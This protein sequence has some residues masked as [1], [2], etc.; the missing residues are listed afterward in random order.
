MFD[1]MIFDMDGTL[2]NF[3]KQVTESWNETC[4]RHKW[5]KTFSYQQLQSIMGLTCKEIGAIF[6]PEID[7]DKAQER[8]ELCCY[9]EVEYLEKHMGETYIPNEMFLKKLSNKYKLFIVSNCQKGY[10]EVFLKHFNYEKYFIETLNSSNGLTK[11]QNIRS[12][13]DKYK[14][15]NAVY[16]GDTIKDQIAANEA[17]VE[18]IHASYGFGNVESKN[19]ITKLEELLDL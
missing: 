12:L 19:K 16:V 18:F 3:V 1:G 14:L 8:V 13:V 17:K 4:K 5:N 9:E 2:V 7:V 6:F 11:S 10:I 15:N